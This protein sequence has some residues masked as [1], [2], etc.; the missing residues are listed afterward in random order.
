MNLASTE[1]SIPGCVVA[2]LRLFLP[3]SFSISH[4]SSG[5]VKTLGETVN[6]AVSQ[7]PNLVSELVD[8]TGLHQ[9]LEEQHEPAN[10]NNDSSSEGEEPAS[11][12]EENPQNDHSGQKNNQKNRLQVCV[13]M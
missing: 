13:V 6:D 1:C 9:I 4:N 12:T 2:I 10:G 8:C 7:I 3:S 11:N 5:P